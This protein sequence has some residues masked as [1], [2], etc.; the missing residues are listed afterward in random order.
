MLFKWEGLV[1]ILQTQTQRLHALVI[2]RRRIQHRVGGNRLQCRPRLYSGSILGNHRV[3][4][5]RG[6]E[7]D[8][9]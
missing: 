3:G 6:E 8:R 7:R 4:I 9:R 1:R 5:R 2:W